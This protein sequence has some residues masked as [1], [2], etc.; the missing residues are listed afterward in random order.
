M[1]KLNAITIAILLTLKSFASFG[2][3]AFGHRLVGE[4][5]KVYVNKSALDSVQK[6]LG[7]TTWADAS[8]WMDEIRSNRF[9]DYLK[10]MHYINVEEGKSYVKLND[11]NII[12]E[13]E[14]VIKELKNKDKLSKDEIN[15]D[16]KI[17]FHL[18]GDLHQPLHVGYG[19]DK[20]G[21]TIDVDF[22][23]ESTN[24]HRVWDTQIIE[25]QKSFKA[26]LIEMSKHLTNE[27]IKKQKIVDVIG[28]MNDSR[29][30]LPQVYA[31]KKGMIDEQYISSVTPIMEKQILYAGIRLA[32]VLNY[33][34]P[35]TTN[36]MAPI[37]EQPE[38]KIKEEDKVSKIICSPDS[39][40]Y[41][42]GSIVTVCGKVS[43]VHLN[44]EGMLFLNFGNPF[45]DNS[46][47]AIAFKDIAPKFKAAEHYNGKHLCIT[48]PI[49][50]YKGKPEIV[51][52]ELNQVKEE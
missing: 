3:G 28:W 43:G 4:I 7:E 21:N 2:W 18:I 16:L 6:F 42:V 29:S 41:H 5:A 47:S 19:I 48:G 32:G 49:K 39:A 35:P 44:K 38:L 33:I 34:F 11:D 30:Y 52:M 15:Q 37:P 24:L 1:K 50:M 46:F 14:K 10:P 26:E 12:N 31:F 13:L 36:D 23:G 40:K 9:Y 51:L 27:E 20:G 45:P 8:V 17:L 25:H 22:L